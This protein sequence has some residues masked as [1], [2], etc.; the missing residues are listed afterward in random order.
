MIQLKTIIKKRSL[1][2]FFFV[3]FFSESLTSQ[4]DNPAWFANESLVG[5]VVSQSGEDFR[6]I[7]VGCGVL[8]PEGVGAGDGVLYADHCDHSPAIPVM[9]LTGSSIV[10]GSIVD[11]T[12][13]VSGLGCSAL[14]NRRFIYGTV[15]AD[16]NS[17]LAGMLHWTSLNID[18]TGSFGNSTFSLSAAGLTNN[19]I[20][21]VRVH[22]AN[23]TGRN[24]S[25]TTSSFFTYVE[26]TSLIPEFFTIPDAD[27]GGNSGD[28][29]KPFPNEL[30]RFKII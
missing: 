13:N 5:D 17:S 19:E 10:T 30:N 24:Y 16:V 15:E 4:C 1:L 7:S 29:R 26:I 9:T 12:G 23:A 25:V 27:L 14:T 8:G 28:L 21:Y 11:F 2:V 20:Y 22:K 3:L 6:L 18:E